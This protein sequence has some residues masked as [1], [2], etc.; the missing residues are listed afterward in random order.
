MGGKTEGNIGRERWLCKWIRDALEEAGFI[1]DTESSDRIDIAIKNPKDGHNV[2]V[3]EAKF[4][5]CHDCYQRGRGHR[6]SK[7]VLKDIEKRRPHGLPH[8]EIVLAADYQSMCPNG[9]DLGFYHSDAISSHLAKHG[10]PGRAHGSIAAGL[11][12]LR[13]TCS[14]NSKPRVTF[15]HGAEHTRRTTPGKPSTLVHQSLSVLGCSVWCQENQTEPLPT[16]PVQVPGC[17]ATL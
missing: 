17:P 1:A 13:K 6:F 11:S 3:I 8:Q 14:R 12:V 5:F 7:N 10:P 2:C 15:F 9:K 4:L 16:F